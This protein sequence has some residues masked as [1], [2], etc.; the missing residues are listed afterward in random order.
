MTTTTT[1]TTVCTP[2]SDPGHFRRRFGSILHKIV[3]VRRHWVIPYCSISADRFAESLRIAIG[4][5]NLPPIC[6][7]N[8]RPR[9]RQ[10][11][12]TTTP[13]HRTTQTIGFLNAVSFCI[14]A[15]RCSSSSSS[16]LMILQKNN[17]CNENAVRVLF[18]FYCWISNSVQIY[19]NRW[20]KAKQSK[21]R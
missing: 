6:A 5:S 18:L 16:E 12:V 2:Q 21:A 17:A 15:L 11:W 19:I 14:R 20:R 1:T 8:N 3:P 13:P 10:Y 9:W 4:G 7:N